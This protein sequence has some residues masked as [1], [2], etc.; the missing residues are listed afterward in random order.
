MF[1]FHEGLAMEVQKHKSQTKGRVTFGLPC[2]GDLKSNFPN[3]GPLND[4]LPR[5]PS[6]GFLEQI[7]K[8]GPC[9]SFLF[10]K[11]P[12]KGSHNKCG[13]ENCYL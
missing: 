1:A 3:K 2:V 12:K 6:V 4:W 10:V 11:V 13:Y 5:R 9:D 8:E 7:P